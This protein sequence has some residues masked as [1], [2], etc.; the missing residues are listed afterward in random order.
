[1]RTNYYQEPE[2]EIYNIKKSFQLYHKR[3]FKI[4]K[5]LVRKYFCKG[6]KILDLC[7]GY[8]EWN[9]NK[10]DVIG[11]DICKPLIET[12]FKEQRISKMI[13]ADAL[14]NGL[15]ANSFDII[16]C[17]GTFEH[18]NYPSEL[19]KECKRLLKKEGILIVSVPY[20]SWKGLWKPLIK[21]RCFLN[22]TI[23]GIEYYKNNLGHINQFT[24]E[25]LIPIFQRQNFE[26]LEYVNNLTLDFYLV[27]KKGE[28]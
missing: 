2:L 16:V 19:A 10:Q 7:C 18:F 5:E 13:I 14:N 17:T 6:N 20:E 15:K 4:T 24:K 28:Q 1:M 27:L 3:R 11:V 9:E 8:A 26:V 21:L 22:G 23:K 25:S 12:A